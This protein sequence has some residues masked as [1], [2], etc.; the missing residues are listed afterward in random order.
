MD[1]ECGYRALCGGCGACAT[2]VFEELPAAR[3]TVN[4]RGDL[5]I[6]TTV[7]DRCPACGCGYV[8]I[9]VK[10]RRAG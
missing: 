5:V 3:L 2:A 7:E 1:S 4:V 9:Q 6:R 8:E 10:T